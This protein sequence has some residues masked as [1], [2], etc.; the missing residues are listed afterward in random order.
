MCDAALGETCTVADPSGTP[1][2]VRKSP[3]GQV[4]G[5]LNNG[6]LVS[7]E[8]RRGD[9]VSVVPRSGKSGWVFLKFLDCAGSSAVRPIEP[10]IVPTPVEIDGNAIL[11]ACTSN[12]P[13]NSEFCHTYMTAVGDT[14]A[15]VRGLIKEQFPICMQGRITSQMGEVVVKYIRENP[16]D[17]HLKAAT[18][19]ALAFKDA[20]PCGG[21]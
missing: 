8:E 20:W 6:I 9:W 4:I 17:R 21:N 11:Y 14:L 2:N 16:R 19:S 3:Y 12:D 5:A 15:F 7:T 18:I 1:L 13:K 10:M